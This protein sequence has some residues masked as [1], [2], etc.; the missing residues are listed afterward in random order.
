MGTLKNNELPKFGCMKIFGLNRYVTIWDI[1]GTG[2][3]TA[4]LSK[5]DLLSNRNIGPI[6]YHHVLQISE[7]WQMWLEGMR[8]VLILKN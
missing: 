3:I 8:E 7:A 1:I 6:P 5:V 2:P 4:N